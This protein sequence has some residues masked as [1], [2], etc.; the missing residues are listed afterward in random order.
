MRCHC[1]SPPTR[2]IRNI[3]VAWLDAKLGYRPD[4]WFEREGYKDQAKKYVKHWGHGAFVFKGGHCDNVTF[5]GA[6]LMDW[7]EDVAVIR[8]DA[9]VKD[10]LVALVRAAGDGGLDLT[11]VVPEYELAYGTPFPKRSKKEKLR[12]AL[13]R[14]EADGAIKVVSVDERGKVKVMVQLPKGKLTAGT[15]ARCRSPSHK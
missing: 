7:T 1:W 8:P 9:F 6:M 2:Y 5:A 15:S 14:F 4:C 11:R 10:N 12:D 13:R 3:P